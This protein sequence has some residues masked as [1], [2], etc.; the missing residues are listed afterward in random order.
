MRWI[1]L[2]CR[3]LRPGT[4]SDGRGGAAYSPE[5]MVR[6][7]LFAYCEGVRSSRQIERRCARD[8]AYRV[9]SGNR[10]PDHATIA[11]FRT[12][13]LEA[14]PAVF[15]QVLRLCAAAGLVRVGLVALDGTKLTADASSF[16]NYDAGQ[17]EKAIA[18]LEAQVQQ[19][20]AEAAGQDAAEDAAERDGSDP[21]TP[22]ELQ[23]PTQRLAKL[24][25][26]KQRLDAEAAKAQRVQEQRRV[27][28]RRL[29]D[30]R[31]PLP[32]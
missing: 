25:A 21:T 16:H 30:E 18:E 4:V 13:H 26:A 7:L 3:G 14:L 27:D 5:V 15:V 1:N 20:L 8:V 12:E 10:V 6:L 17:L 2:I 29:Q 9:L 28:G 19:M 22:P 23:N 24:R 32:G 11:R 31:A